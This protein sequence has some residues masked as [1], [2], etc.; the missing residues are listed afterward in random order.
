MFVVYWWCG[1]Y[2]KEVF[3]TTREAADRV[4]EKFCRSEGTVRL[5]EGKDVNGVVTLDWDAPI[6]ERKAEN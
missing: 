5:Y 2:D 6:R 3:C 4:F 1:F